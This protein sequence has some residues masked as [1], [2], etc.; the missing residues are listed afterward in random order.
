MGTKSHPRDIIVTEQSSFC[1]KGN[2][3][4]K[5]KNYEKTQQSGLKSL[6]FLICAIV[7]SSGNLNLIHIELLN[8]EPRNATT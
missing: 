1:L 8:P 7:P 5:L 2:A 6:N 4:E 3:E